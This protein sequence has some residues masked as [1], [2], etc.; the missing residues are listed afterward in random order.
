MVRNRTNDWNRVTQ[1]KPCRICGKPDWCSISDDGS[2]VICGRV[3]SEKPIGSSGF[4]HRLKKSTNNRKRRR[5]R[6][7]KTVVRGAFDQLH[8]VYL[9]D[10]QP[11][12]VDYLAN[13]L[14]VTPESLRRFEIGWKDDQPRGYTFPV[15]YP[16]QEIC[17]LQ[18]R[19]L[20]G[21]KCVVRASVTS[22]L[23]IPVGIDPHRVVFV[24]EGLSDACALMTRG[25]QAIGRF[26]AATKPAL[27]IG[28]V[29]H[30][31]INHVVIVGDL[32]AVGHQAAVRC[33]E[34]CRS[35]VKTRIL[36]PPV[37][38]VRE[39]IR[40]AASREDVIGRISDVA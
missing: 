24:T 29:R 39:W 13:Q 1:D 30:L 11:R 28:A 10:L 31:R 9:D 35:F 20:D 33:A 34:Y 19:S 5:R 16:D 15:R 18:I 38:D 4:L 36:L 7:I 40:G 14:G 27:V 23:F 3:E 37:K 26:S 32:D 25:F 6:T 12:Q 22:G 21:C 2:A 17:G 8:Q